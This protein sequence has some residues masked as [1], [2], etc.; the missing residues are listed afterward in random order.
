MTM[1][2]TLPLLLLLTGLPVLAQDW[3]ASLSV[4]KTTPRGS[5]VLLERSTAAGD[6]H[7]RTSLHNGFTQLGLAG[8][9]R[10]AHRDQVAFWLTGELA[11]NGSV[12]YDKA[13]SQTVVS[14]GVPVRITVENFQGTAKV[15]SWALGGRLDFATQALGE[16][17]GGVAVRRQTL[18]L[19]GTLTTST[20]NAS[21]GNL[22]T[23]SVS[24]SL[25]GAYWDVAVSG[26]VTMVQ[27]HATLRT[28]QR[29][30]ATLA[31]PMGSRNQFD[32][33]ASDWKLSGR[34]LPQFQPNHEF[35]VA[36][37]LRI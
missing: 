18:S 20:T 24:R 28:F 6:T 8:A 15:R 35:L 5:D 17:S 1:R 16:L 7:V 26:S 30:T 19:D 14:G 25:S 32:L 34:Y 3:E 10:L 27:R 33:Q 31:I 12:D 13:G 23:S 4:R 36:F 37:G 11:L 22:T 21:T 9:Y 29:L 2:S